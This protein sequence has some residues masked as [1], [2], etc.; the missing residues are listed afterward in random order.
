MQLVVK[1]KDHSKT[2][3]LLTSKYAT[4]D[5]PTDSWKRPCI[6]VIPGANQGR[7]VSRK[8][9][10]YIYLSVHMTPGEWLQQPVVY[11]IV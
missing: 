8:R 2:P 11:S 7:I 5:T 1:K 9:S 10:D 4:W 3:S 6:Q